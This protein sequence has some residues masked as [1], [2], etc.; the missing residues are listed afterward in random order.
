MGEANAPRRLAL[1]IGDAR[2]DLTTALASGGTS[3]AEPIPEW[4]NR[5]RRRS[6]LIVARCDERMTQLRRS[7]AIAVLPIFAGDLGRRG[8]AVRRS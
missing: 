4:F 6:S 1:T 2:Q 3:R 8:A 5:R 7:A